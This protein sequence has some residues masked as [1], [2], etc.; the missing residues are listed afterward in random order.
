MFKKLNKQ[1][2]KIYKKIKIYK[3]NLKKRNNSKN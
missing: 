2:N 3:K 1:I